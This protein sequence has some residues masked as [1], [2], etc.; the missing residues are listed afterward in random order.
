MNVMRLREENRLLRSDLHEAALRLAIA[1]HKEYQV[2]DGS[3]RDDY[4]K[5]CSAIETWIDHVSEVSDDA[6]SEY[7]RDQYIQ[8]VRREDKNQTLRDLGID[9]YRSAHSVTNLNWLKDLDTLHYYILSLT[10][11]KFIFSG[12]LMRQYPVGTTGPQKMI[13]SSIEAEM[14]RMG[15]AKSKKNQWR[16]DTLRAL[17]ASEEFQVE[18]D[19]Q[20]KAL[21]KNLQGEL[22]LWLRPSDIA[23]HQNRLEQNIFNPAVKLHM[24]MQ[25]SAQQ[26]DLISPPADDQ[27]V[28]SSRSYDESHE[29]V[30]EITNWKT[31]ARNATD[32]NVLCIYP[33][34]ITYNVEAEVES[35]LV[36]PVMAVLKRSTL[37]PQVRHSTKSPARSSSQGSDASSNDPRDAKAQRFTAGTPKVP[38]TSNYKLVGLRSLGSPSRRMNDSPRSP[39]PSRRSRRS[40]QDTNTSSPRHEQSQKSS[41]FTPIQQE[42]QR[43]ASHSGHSY[44]PH[45][46]ET[47]RSRPHGEETIIEGDE[48]VQTNYRALS[49]EPI[50]ESFGRPNMHNTWHRN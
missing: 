19:S 46:S 27:F 41:Y 12:I 24:D 36:K 15:K 37:L 16:A 50:D 3:I 20:L 25:C 35:E 17:C 49:P 28:S 43:S 18:Q 6:F 5:L 30:K 26:Y 21:W 48:A 47:Q 33:G 32:V 39:E 38:A 29:S 14:L 1:A 23:K 11:G 40:S 2:P 8:A 31:R 7:F 10:V 13:F 45:H 9:W 34:I 44:L 22:S 4:Q 42:R